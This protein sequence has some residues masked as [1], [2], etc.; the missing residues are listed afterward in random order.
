VCLPSCSVRSGSKPWQPVGV[1][2][3][4]KYRLFSSEWRKTLEAFSVRL[5]DEMD[6]EAPNNELVSVVQETLATEASLRVAASRAASKSWLV[7]ASGSPRA[8]FI[9]SRCKER[10]VRG[11]CG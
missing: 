10:V 2:A 8:E 5:R 3:R 11:I 7:E 1:L 9:V 4:Q 6:L